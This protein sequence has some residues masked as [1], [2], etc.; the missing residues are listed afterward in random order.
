[1]LSADTVLTSDEEESSD[2]DEA[3]EEDETLEQMGKSVEQMLFENKTRKEVR[4]Y[5]VLN[6]P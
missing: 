6:V 5:C 2:E 4:S 1:M 3:A